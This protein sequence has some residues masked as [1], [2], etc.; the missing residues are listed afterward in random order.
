M[1]SPP[2]GSCVQP[3]GVDRHDVGVAH[4][5]QRRRRRDRV[6][7]MRATNEARP[8]VGSHRSIV[9]A[10]PLDVGLQHV[11]VARLVTRTAACRR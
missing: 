7:S 4:Q 9:D 11:G 3:V 8:G 10:R 5:A 6:P 2:N 1:S